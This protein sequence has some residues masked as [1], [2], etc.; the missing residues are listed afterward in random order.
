MDDCFVYMQGLVITSKGIE[1]TA[2]AEIKELINAKCKIENTCVVFDFDDFKDLCLLCYKCQS[3]DRA[4][5]LIGDFEFTDFF[6]DFERFIDKVKIDELI[7]N[8]KKF[9][10]ECIRLGT[11]HFKSVDV[12]AKAAELLQKKLKTKNS[13]I[14][15]K[16]YEIIYFAYIVDNKCYF[17]IDFA[18]FELNK[19]DYKIFLHPNSLR[20]TIAYALFRESGFEKKDVVLDPF[21]RDGVIVI[22]AAFY[23]SN[24]PYTYYKKEKFAF[25]KLNLGI[26]FEKFFKDIDKNI[27][28][29]KANINCFDH[30]FKYIDYSK[31]NAKI[32]GVDKQINF[33]RVELEW[34]DIKFKEKS[35][36][37]IITNPPT[38]KNTDLD[39]IYNEF[40]YQ[41]EYIL[42]SDGTVS[43]ITRLPDFVKK[44]AEKHNFF[45]SKEKE[46]W[47]GE[48]LLKIIIFKKKSI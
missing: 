46:V 4:L 38:S 1:E 47:S 29:T 2:S 20:G 44:H 35:V 31:K 23:A 7:C 42:K 8:N 18:G 41:C 45:A 24:F 10:I 25:L 14:D 40:F 30:M 16:D 33:S 17:G 6:K 39:K 32:A 34:L 28:K 48:Q 26:D 21:S 37:R 36:D 11:H 19:R 15:K 5:Y 13:K 3:A 12:E 9:K 22:E 43:L 27:K